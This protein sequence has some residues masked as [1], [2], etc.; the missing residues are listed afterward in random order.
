MKAVLLLGALL[1]SV[2]L[3]KR[4]R[5]DGHFNDDKDTNILI[6]FNENERELFRGII[7]GVE[8]S[9]YKNPTDSVCVQDVDTIFF[10]IE[11]MQGDVL[12][13][14]QGDVKD[15]TSY[16]EAI[17]AMFKAYGDLSGACKLGDFF[18]DLFKT[19]I[20]PA[21]WFGEARHFFRNTKMVEEY[22]M[23][24][25]DNFIKQNYFMMGAAV[26]RVIYEIFGV[27]LH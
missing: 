20:N 6:W 22:G 5:Y 3:A 9:R 27:R 17:M 11:D 13:I 26:G 23:L 2:V 8:G 25:M 7:F 21:Y 14:L 19:V 1:A 12:A 18:W 16:I 10:A 24:F 4:E 15:T